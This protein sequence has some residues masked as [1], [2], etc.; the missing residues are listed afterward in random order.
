[1]RIVGVAHT[2]LARTA[3]PRYAGYAVA[4]P[5]TAI[6]DHG[7]G[8]ARSRAF[9]VIF[10]AICHLLDGQVDARCCSATNP[11]TSANC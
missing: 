1:M 9:S 2:D 3:D 10:L 11:S 7:P 6:D 4:V 8:M 5:S